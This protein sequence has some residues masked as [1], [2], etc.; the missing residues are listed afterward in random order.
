MKVTSPGKFSVFGLVQD[1]YNTFRNYRSGKFSPADFIV[2][3][4]TPT[5]SGT[6]SWLLSLKANNVP[7]V[8]SAVAILTGL[9]FG[10]FVL[11][12]D[13]SMRA[14]ETRE[15]SQ[16][17]KITKLVEELRANVSYAVLLG[18]VLTGI[19]S[20]IAM[21]KPDDKSPIGIQLTAVIIFLGVQ[22][23]LTI[24]MI[25]KRVRATFRGFYLEFEEKIP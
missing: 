10:V 20:S 17:E 4:G 2:Y 18:L 13:L 9:I 3:L 14:S 7:E 25:L 11:I 23:L 21:F 1:H 15:S 19:I 16:R 24:L 8:L 12:F 22:L 6:V 5:L